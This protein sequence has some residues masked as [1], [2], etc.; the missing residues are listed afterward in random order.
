MNT[1]GAGALVEFSAPGRP[2]PQGSHRPVVTKQAAG[3]RARRVV[4]PGT[5]RVVTYGAQKAPRVVMPGW[6]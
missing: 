4:D 1:G 3:G 6:S 2:V 5:G